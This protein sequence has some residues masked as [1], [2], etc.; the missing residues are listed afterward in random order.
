ML[1]SLRSGLK[2]VFQFLAK[3]FIL[4]KIN[5]N[6]VSLLAIPFSLATAYAYATQHWEWALVLLPLSGLWDAID[7]AVARAQKKQSLWGNYFETMIDKLVEILTF[8]G[9]AFVSPAASITALGFGLWSSYAKPRVGLVIITDNH[10]WPAIGEHADKMVLLW[11][12]TLWAFLDSGNAIHTLTYTLWLIAAISAVG[13][14]QR[15][16]YAKKLI[17]EAEKKGMI[18]PYLKKGKER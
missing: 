16:E 17:A 6:H 18:L 12:G 2:P 11:L 3:P 13:A 7:G 8:I 9:L 15:M 10:D 1:S 4:L 14:L 5:P